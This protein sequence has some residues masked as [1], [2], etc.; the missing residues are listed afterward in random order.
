MNRFADHVMIA[1][2]VL[3]LFAGAVM[4]ALGGERHRIVNAVLNVVTTF[5]LVIISIGLLRAADAAPTGLAGVY[6][7]GNWP[8]PFAIVLV[9]DR[10]SA[11]ML[12]LTS[13][14]AAAAIVFSLARWHRVGVLFHADAPGV[15]RC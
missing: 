3:P 11:L 6:R 5:A 10:L 9:L 7:V 1:P 2:V 8:A 4:L 15:C 14:L 13:M 12:L